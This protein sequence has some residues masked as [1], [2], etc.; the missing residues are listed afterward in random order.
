MYVVELIFQLIGFEN[1]DFF[2]I[3]NFKFVT[4]VIPLSRE[5]SALESKIQQDND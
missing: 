2:Q 3:P 4:P 1:L 5:K